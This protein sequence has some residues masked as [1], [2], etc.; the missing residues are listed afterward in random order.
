VEAIVELMR[1]TET[2]DQAMSEAV[3]G[4]RAEGYS[5]GEIAAR[6]NVTRQAVYQRFG[7]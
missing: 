6:M 2:L 7:K 4:L 3:L 1:L 5:W